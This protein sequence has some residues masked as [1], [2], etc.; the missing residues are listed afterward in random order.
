MEKRGWIA[1]DI[2]GT[3]TLDKYSVPQPVIDYLRSLHE[4]GWNIALATGRAFVFAARAIEKFDFPFFLLPQN[5]SIALEMPEKKIVFKRYMPAAS[6]KV[7]DAAFE[8]FDCDFVVYGGFERGDACFYR[9]SRMSPEDLLY[10]EDVRKREKESWVSVERFDLTHDVPLIKCFG[11]PRRMKV[12]EG[13][14]VE[15][16]IFQLSHI[17]DVFHES[18]DILLVT[19]KS[20]SKG[21]S[22][23]EL[24]RLKG[25]GERVIA[26]GDDM[27]DVTL[28]EAADVKIAMAHAPEKLQEIADFI[29]PP[30]KEH[31]IIRALQMS[32]R[33]GR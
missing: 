25:K 13:R 12:V 18:Y 22:L 8:G 21:A 16:G 14:L 29:A 7:V 20:A 19:D 11:H 10:T 3:I 5:G 1:L 32:L 2:D 9:P 23:K 24:L 33:N 28:L 31:G 4:E 15:K 27:N 6:V 17:R 30:T 26:A